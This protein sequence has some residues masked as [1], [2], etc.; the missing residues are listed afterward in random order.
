MLIP[1]IIRRKAAFGCSS[2]VFGA[3]IEHRRRRHRGGSL[4]SDC[5]AESLDLQVSF[6]VLRDCGVLFASKF[7]VIQSRYSVPISAA[8]V[9]NS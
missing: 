6:G 3:T 2:M 9:C 5:S 1:P 4:A 8:A 7:E